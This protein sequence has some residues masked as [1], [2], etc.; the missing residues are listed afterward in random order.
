MLQIQPLLNEF[1][2]AGKKIS[3]LSGQSKINMLILAALF[4]YEVLGAGCVMQ[5]LPS[6]NT[7]MGSDL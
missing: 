3:G 1:S 5:L 4:A 6:Y 2:A 7:L